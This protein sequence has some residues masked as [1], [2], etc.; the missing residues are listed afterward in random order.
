MGMEE[1]K[2]NRTDYGNG[3]VKRRL[4]QGLSPSLFSVVIE[5]VIHTYLEGWESSLIEMPR[6]GVVLPSLCG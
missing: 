3:R 2:G 6:G 4:R 5:R 1:S